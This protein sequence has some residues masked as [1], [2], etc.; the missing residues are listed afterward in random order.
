MQG[1][2]NGN[3]P[4]LERFT[5]TLA[6]TSRWWLKRTNLLVGACLLEASQL[7][8]SAHGKKTRTLGNLAANLAALMSTCGISTKS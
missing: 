3:A 7:A 2:R 5:S 4:V 6:E 1:G 8:C